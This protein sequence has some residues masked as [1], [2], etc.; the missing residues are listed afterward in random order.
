MPKLTETPVRSIEEAMA[1][2]NGFGYV[3]DFSDRTMAMFFDD[4]FSVD[5]YSEKYAHRG[6]SKRNHL[7]CFLLDSDTHSALQVLRALWERR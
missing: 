4:E 2:P 7:I 3:L 5:I 1:Y 6:S